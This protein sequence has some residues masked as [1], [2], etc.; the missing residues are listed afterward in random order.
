MS[1][2]ETVNEKVLPS[3]MKFIN[4]R[5]VQAIKDGMLFI[6]PL[7]IVGSIFLLLAEFPFA[8]VKD[9]FAN[10]GWAPAMYQANNATIGIMALVAVVGIAY[11]FA[12]NE[13]LEPLSAGFAALVSNFL[14]LNWSVPAEGTETGFVGGIPSNW[15]GSS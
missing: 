4:L 3:V 5:P 10:V 13:G 12:K 14:L 1:F 11:S 15:L 6:M 7:S 9:F 2:S 8:P